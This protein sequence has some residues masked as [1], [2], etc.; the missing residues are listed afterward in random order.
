L[1]VEL[2]QKQ[3]KLSQ[4][5]LSKKELLNFTPASITG[6]SYFKVSCPVLGERKLTQVF[7]EK[8]RKKLEISPGRKVR[9]GWVG[10]GRSG[11][12]RFMVGLVSFEKV[13]FPYMIKTLSLEKFLCAR[14]Q[15]QNVF[16]RGRV[17]S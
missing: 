3:V 16:S 15:C 11:L 4:N 6:R 9:L 10:L 1:R 2:N 12:S 17:V 7:Q 5:E 13:I 8:I 14:L